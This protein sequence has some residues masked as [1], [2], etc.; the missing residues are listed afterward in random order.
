MP[1]PY[2]NLIAGMVA[3][4]PAK[5]VVLQ[6]AG[7][8]VRGQLV[9]Y[10]S[11]DT[12]G[13]DTVKPYVGGANDVPYGVLADPSVVVTTTKRASVYLGGEFNLAALIIDGTIAVK[14][15]VEKLRKVGI[16]AKTV[17]K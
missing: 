3:P 16:I 1:I 2:D 14:D 8:F 12:A 15:H 10:V 6:G 4:F 13:V 17:V 11:T 5:G 7:T 9:Q